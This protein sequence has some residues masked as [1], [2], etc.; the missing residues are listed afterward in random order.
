MVLVVAG[1]GCLLLGSKNGEKINPVPSM[2]YQSSEIVF[3][4]S[5]EKLTISSASSSSAC[6]LDMYGSMSIIRL[7]T[8]LRKQQ[9]HSS[10]AVVMS[11]SN[12]TW[13][14]SEAQL[15][16]ILVHYILKHL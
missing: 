7:K 14:P 1:V 13:D 8:A 3:Y 12:S 10:K 9:Q 6:T 4:K 16:L 2:H 5:G 15:S 11:K